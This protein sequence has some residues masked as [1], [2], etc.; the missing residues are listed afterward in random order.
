MTFSHLYVM[1]RASKGFLNSKRKASKQFLSIVSQIEIDFDG[2]RTLNG[3]SFYVR[4]QFF[5]HQI[6]D[7]FF[8]FNVH[9]PSFLLPFIISDFLCHLRLFVLFHIILSITT[10]LSF[11]YH[12]RFLFTMHN[13]PHPQSYEFRTNA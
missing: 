8:V 1:G 11:I 10:H 4:Q 7:I 2:E 6:F 13:N 12:E 3:G 9:L 5:F